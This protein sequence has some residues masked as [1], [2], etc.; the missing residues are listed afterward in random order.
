[1]SP[2]IPP[3]LPRVFNVLVAAAWID[4]AFVAA[5]ASPVSGWLLSGRLIPSVING[6][7]L[8]AVVG[9]WAGSIYLWFVSG[10]QLGSSVAWPIVLVPLGFVLGAVYILRLAS[11]PH[12]SEAVRGRS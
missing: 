2:E 3:R 8:L 11:R 5:E 9:A 7:A 6:V 1:M 4:L 10:R 12:Q